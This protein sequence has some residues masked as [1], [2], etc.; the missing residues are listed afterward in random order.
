M[1][2]TLLLKNGNEIVKKSEKPAMT[3]TFSMENLLNSKI[4]GKLSGQKNIMIKIKKENLNQ[5]SLD[6]EADD[7]G[8][9]QSNDSEGQ[10]DYYSEN[11]ISPNFESHNQKSEDSENKNFSEGNYDRSTSP[12]QESQ[13]SVVVGNLE[14]SPTT[15]DERFDK[16]EPSGYPLQRMNLHHGDNFQS[17]LSQNFFKHESVFSQFFRNENYLISVNNAANRNSVYFGNQNLCTFDCYRN[18]K[19]LPIY[20]DNRHFHRCNSV[21]CISCEN[22]KMQRFDG[23]SGKCKGIDK[24]EDDITVS[25]KQVKGKEEEMERSSIQ[26]SSPFRTAEMDC[27]PALKFSVNAILGT[28]H[29]GIHHKPGRI[30]NI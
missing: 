6:S 4:V 1:L 15:E 2:E 24:R 21:N 22:S 13:S 26:T 9:R 11:S 29:Q 3:S 20:R 23:H 10:N 25:L 27:K 7:E 12:D 19:S 17:N 5:L 30:S 8:K 16:R 14:N 28:N 18:S